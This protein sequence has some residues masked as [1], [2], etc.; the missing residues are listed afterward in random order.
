M[1][2]DG[3]VLMKSRRL[4][5]C[6]LPVLVRDAEEAMSQAVRVKAPGKFLKTVLFKEAIAF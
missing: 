1:D 4:V 6:L 5:V 3:V 2:L